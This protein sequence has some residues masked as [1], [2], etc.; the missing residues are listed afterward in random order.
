MQKK[1]NEQMH[2]ER[3]LLILVALRCVNL[4]FT[5]NLKKEVNELH[6]KQIRV[7]PKT[8]K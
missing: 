4:S 3:K 6:Q 8:N 1:K 5:M 2:F 7:T